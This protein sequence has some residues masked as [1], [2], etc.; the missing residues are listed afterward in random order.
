M[1]TK[2]WRLG[3]LSYFISVMGKHMAY[4]LIQLLTAWQIQLP[5]LS[6]VHSSVFTAS[7]VNPQSINFSVSAVN[8]SEAI[9]S[10]A[11]HPW[12]SVN[13][14]PG[15]SKGSVQSWLAGIPLSKDFWTSQRCKG[16]IGLIPRRGIYICHPKI[17]ACSL[18]FWRWIHYG[19]GWHRK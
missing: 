19:L 13:P 4:M 9:I 15:T 18:L 14:T 11:S 12:S 8:H 5:R 3:W 7:A 16:N 2:S 1:I 6:V 17:P 10:I